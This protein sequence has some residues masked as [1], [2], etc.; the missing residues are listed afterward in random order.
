EAT[1]VELDARNARVTGEGVKPD[2][3]GRAGLKASLL[4]QPMWI[5]Y[6]CSFFPVIALVFYLRSLLYEPFK[7]PSTSMLPTLEVGDLILVNKYQYGIRL[8]VINK[9]IIELGVPQRGDVMVF[10]YPENPSLDY[11]KRV[12]GVPGDTVA[13]KNKK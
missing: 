2:D 1:L 4:R 9:K 11:I 6:S 8:P 13:Y 3:N 5:E 7:I 10:K 12:V